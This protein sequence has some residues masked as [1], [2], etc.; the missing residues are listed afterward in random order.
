MLL[1]TPITDLYILLRELRYNYL[2]A[3]ICNPMTINLYWTHE[4]ILDNY[5]SITTAEHV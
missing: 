4:C 5:Y 1:A 3:D 2:G